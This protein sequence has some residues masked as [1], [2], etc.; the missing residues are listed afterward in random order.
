M[1]AGA[2]SVYDSGSMAESYDYRPIERKWQERWEADAI[3]RAHDDDPRP[4]YYVL[5]MLPYPSGD[6][7]VGHAKNYTLGDSVAR[8]MRMLGYNVLHPMGWDAFGLPAE[9]AA[10]ARGVD[11]AT[12]TAENVLNMRRQ[13]RLMGTSYDW[14]REIATCEPEYYRWNQW[15]FLRLYEEGLAYKREAP[16]NW[17]PHDRTVLAN[18]Q[19]IDGRCWRCDHLVER[20]QFVAMVLED[21]GL[22][23]TPARRSRKVERLAGTHAHDAA[24]LDRPQ[25]RRAVR[26]RSGRARRKDRSLHDARRH[27]LRCDVRC[28]RRRASG[29]RAP[30]D[31]RFEKERRRDR[32]VCGEPRIQV[33]TRTHEFDGEARSLHRSVR[34]QSTL[35]RTR[36]DLGDELRAGGVRNRR[37]DGRTRAR[38][39][40]LRFRTQTRAAGGASDRTQRR[41]AG[42][43]PDAGVP[44]RW[45][46]DCQRRFQRHVERTRA[47]R[48]RRPPRCD[49]RG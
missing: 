45:T 3:Y 25:R 10:I 20:A 49:R 46:F 4:K 47:R 12:W 40:R 21:H 22:R 11:P 16:V 5:E 38:R 8:I 33:G 29:D 15:L 48:H 7:H 13:L 18:E 37:G 14:T 27:A 19:V 36:A 9:N 6:L 31:H 26:I 42:R 2:A 34:D 17:C 32:R 28:D 24:Q 44:R 35:A 43:A 1:A 39:T 30:K 23:A 41:R